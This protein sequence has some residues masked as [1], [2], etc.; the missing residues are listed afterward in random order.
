MEMTA[1]CS[2]PSRCLARRRQSCSQHNVTKDDETKLKKSYP[3]RKGW[4]NLDETKIRVK[5]V[6]SLGMSRQRQ[7]QNRNY[8]YEQAR[9]TR[10]ADKAAALMFHHV[11]WDF[12]IAFL[13][14]SHAF[15][16]GRLKHNKHDK[17]STLYRFFVVKLWNRQA[18]LVTPTV[19]LAM[20]TLASVVTTAAPV[21]NWLC[22]FRYVW[23]LR[24]VV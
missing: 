8:K 7:K 21:S 18:D 14:F 22:H 24:T 20:R 15:V 6:G 17:H 10:L 5:G 13:C 4:L 23:E 16:L 1:T 9:S 11:S 3:R 12:I 19:G 2:Q